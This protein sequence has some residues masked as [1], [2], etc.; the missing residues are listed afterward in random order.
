MEAA[1]STC[2]SESTGGSHYSRHRP[3]STL[4]YQI[5]ERHYPQFL[6]SLGASGR[7]LIQRFGSALNLNVHFHLLMPD[8]VYLRGAE[9]PVFVRTSAPALPELQA[10]AERIGSRLGKHLERRGILVRDLEDCYLALDPDSEEDALPDLQGHSINYR[11]ALGRRR[12][13]KARSGSLWWKLVASIG[14]D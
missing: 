13:Q 3:E 6:A 4:L 11:I 1:Q 14:T 9:A 12:G 5:I 7:N 8:G 2:G 10:L